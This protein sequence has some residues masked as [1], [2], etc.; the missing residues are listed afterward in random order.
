MT[1]IT[2]GLLV[3]RSSDMDAALT[4]YRAIGLAFVEE[5]HGSGPVHYS[6][7]LG[8]TVIEIYPGSAQEPLDLGGSGA[9]MLGFNVASLDAVL[10]ALK[11][12]G[13]PILTTPKV[14]AW[15]RRA[16]VHDPDGRAVELNEPVGS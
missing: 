7:I 15:G 10:D 12:I 13:A 11:Q 14:S 8:A 2:L 16:V 6:C 4:F 1:E 5:Q 9:T 3:L